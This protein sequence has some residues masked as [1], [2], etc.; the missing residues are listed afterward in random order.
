MKIGITGVNGFI[1]YHTYYNLKY[2]TDWDII[3][4]DRDFY[5][6]G[7][8]KECDWVIHLAG[9][10]RGDENE[11]YKT[12][13]DLT[14]LLLDSVSTDCNIIFS[15][16]TQ[17]E[18]DNSY[19]KCKLDCEQLIQNWCELYDNIFYNLRIP[20]VFGP[21]CKPN[22]NS[23]VATFCNEVCNDGKPTIINDS[24]VK[25]V[26]IND[27]VDMFKKCIDRNK[28]EFK[29]TDIKVSQV[30]EKLNY[31]KKYYFSEGRV[32]NIN[33]NFDRNLFNTFISY[34]P[35]DKRM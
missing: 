31:Y 20:N 16:S 34:I 26:Y 2:N 22:Y 25:L 14:Q 1:G 29:T 6:D 4:L 17:V 3:Q 23:F 24:V 19:G 13:I 11:V 15:S 27:V 8:I 35:N 7:R 32:P 33:D 12:N 30:L 9:M 28:F 18:L 21:F 10:N 5:N